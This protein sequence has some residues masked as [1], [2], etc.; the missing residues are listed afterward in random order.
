MI[1]VKMKNK[2]DCFCFTKIYLDGFNGFL[3]SLLLFFFSCSIN[4]LGQ[5]NCTLTGFVTDKDSG[6]PIEFASVYLSQ[7]TIGTTSG[8]RGYF[9]LIAPKGVYDLVISSVEFN[10][11]VIKIDTRTKDTTKINVVL[12][13]KTLIVNEISVRDEEDTNWQKQ[14]SIFKKLILGE[15]ENVKEC[16]FKDE[17]YIDFNENDFKIEA[18][19]SKPFFVI[20]SKLG[21]TIECNLA[22]FS[23][24][25]LS[26]KCSYK[27]HTGFKEFNTFNKD[28]L[29]TFAENREKV[30]QGSL[31]HLLN[32]LIKGG[33]EFQKEGFRI[34]YA[35]IRSK[36]FI[37]HNEVFT[38]EEILLF[39]EESNQIFINSGNSGENFNGLQII[40]RESPNSGSS[41]IVTQTS[42]PQIDPS[43]YFLDN[44][45]EL[46]GVM[47]KEGLATML[48]KF[49]SMDRKKN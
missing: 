13:K 40:R 49:Y 26:K 36:G 8:K 45:Y 34:Y 3:I 16:I 30:Y 6:E 2:I 22:N 15:N 42:S 29:E 28:S 17:F 19:S 41:L 10:T 47:A 9:Q 18:K 46:K 33:N 48:P 32:S 37:A 14:F 43:G 12:E 4:S 21:Y 11:K 39:K 44:N 1:K 31:M 24:N 27:L 25:K 35:N 23:Y 7:T 38:A 5:S 20:N